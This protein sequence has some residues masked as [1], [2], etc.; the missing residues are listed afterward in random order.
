[1]FIDGIDRVRLVT[2]RK[3]FSENFLLRVSRKVNHDATIQIDNLLFETDPAFSRKRLE[4]RYEPGWLEDAT[5]A[6]MLY[7][8]GKKVG[9]ARKIRFFDNA[10]VKRKY[11]GNRRKSAHDG[12]N[13]AGAAPLE[14][15]KNTIS[16]SALTQGGEEHV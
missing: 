7:E 14:A 4:V 1:M 5:K 8:D 3:Q 16:F 9:E 13:S 10:H 6:L 15:H 12:E 2:D 11:P